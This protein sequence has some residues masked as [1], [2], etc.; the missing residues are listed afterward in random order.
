MELRVEQLSVQ[1][2]VSVDTIRYY[3]SKSLLDP[4][5]REGRIAWYD[6]RHLERLGRIRS[7]QKRGFTLATIARLVTGE[8]DA[9]DEALLG[10]LSGVRQVTGRTVRQDGRADDP[11]SRHGGGGGD[12]GAGNPGA[13]T[14]A[15]TLSE[16]AIET[17]VPLALLKAIEAEGLL[18]ARRVN[19]Q[20]RYTSED[21]AASKAG[22]LLLE[23]GIPLSALLDLARRHH[24]ATEAVT[25]E[26]VAIFSVYVRGPLRD[27]QR[28]EA[29]GA[30]PDGKT[31]DES[32]DESADGPA[33]RDTDRLLQAYSE[34]LPAVNALVG[35]HFT[36]TLVKAAL[37]HVE[38]VGSDAERRAI[39]DHA[40][41]AESGVLDVLDAERPA[42]S[43]APSR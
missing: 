12:S 14:D 6:A 4:P 42:E 37:D 7:L 40:R 13:H 31:A 17:G 34:L 29:D 25:R 20:E 30:Q 24:E 35:H 43:P 41:L 39:S 11:G 16:L 10:E 15:Y 33:D 21:V 23:W 28:R 18:I 9:A 5:R 1:S 36:R 2:D 27:G 3:Q 32:A 38:L 8:L 26:A 22:L 19:G